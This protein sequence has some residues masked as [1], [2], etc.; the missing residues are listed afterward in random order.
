MKPLPFVAMLA[1][2]A[3]LGV[4]PLVA[5]PLAGPGAFRQMLVRKLDLTQAQQAAI[6]Q[7]LQAQK[8]AFRSARAAVGQARVALAEA[9]VDPATTPAQVQT[10]SATLAS[11]QVALAL[12]VNQLV[13]AVAPSLTPAQIAGAKSLV[14]EYIAKIRDFR[15]WAEAGPDSGM[16]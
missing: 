12:Q 4:Q 1:L 6:H 13:Q 5:Q 16:N 3:L 9:L 2:P 14:A 7:V 10:L 15:A 11:A 8:P